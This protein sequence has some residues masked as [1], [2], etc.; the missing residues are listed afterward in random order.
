MKKKSLPP[1]LLWKI[2]KVVDLAERK[3][4]TFYESFYT[5]LQRI[6]KKQDR[7]DAYDLICEYA[8]FQ[9]EPNLEKIPDS[10]AI[11]FELLRPVLDSAR[12]KAASG[13]QGGSK[14]KANGSKT[15]QPSTEGEKERE[16]EKEEEIDKEIEREEENNFAHAEESLFDNFWNAYPEHARGDSEAAREAWEK[17]NPTEEKAAQIMEYLGYWKESQRWVSDGGAFIPVAKNFLTPEKSYLRTKP[18]PAKKQECRWTP[19]H[20]ELDADDIEAIQ[21][22]MGK[23]I[24]GIDF[25]YENEREDIENGTI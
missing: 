10:V 18:A 13:K 14:K 15:K 9:K 1:W 12:K 25:P 7:A 4:F 8:L 24:P 11:A 17:L 22:M 6:K 3:Q 5:G 20:R 19:G 21:R 16:I 23:K 2:R